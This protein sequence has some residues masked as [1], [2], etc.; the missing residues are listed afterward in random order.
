MISI[1][2]TLRYRSDWELLADRIID[3]DPWDMAMLM[4]LIQAHDYTGALTLARDLW[5]PKVIGLPF[6][7]TVIPLG[8][9]PGLSGT[10][11]LGLV[12]FLRDEV[13]HPQ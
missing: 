1:K 7:G 5:G 3:H 6:G 13:V 8:T 12:R 4:G 11:L 2:R 9:T 10:A